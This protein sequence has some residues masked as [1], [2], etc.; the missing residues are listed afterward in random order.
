MSTI[1]DFMVPYHD[2]TEEEVKHNMKK[3]VLRYMLNKSKNSRKSKQVL[4]FD[5]ERPP[6]YKTNFLAELLWGDNYARVFIQHKICMGTAT[7]RADLQKL[8]ANRE[9]LLA[10]LSNPVPARCIAETWKGLKRFVNHTDSDKSRLGF[11]TEPTRQFGGSFSLVKPDDGHD[12]AAAHL[13]NSRYSMQLKLNA[14]KKKKKVIIPF[15]GITEG[16]PRHD[17]WDGIV[18]LR[19]ICMAPYSR[20]KLC[21][22]TSLKAG[23]STD[24]EEEQ[25]PTAAALQRQCDIYHAATK[26]FTDEVHRAFELQ[27]DANWSYTRACEQKLRRR[28]GEAEDF[29]KVAFKAAMTESPAIAAAA[30]VDPQNTSTQTQISSTRVTTAS[31]HAN[32]ASSMVAPVISRSRPVAPSQSPAGPA[33]HD[34]PVTRGRQPKRQRDRTSPPRN[35]NPLGGFKGEAAAAAQADYRRKKNVKFGNA[36]PP[37]YKIWEEESMKCVRREISP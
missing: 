32:G 30:K 6:L 11:G 4:D 12:D 33:S 34:E 31:N 26:G 20:S 8:E 17:W 13:A 29:L 9:A 5:K 36:P 27:Y 21:H 19:G 35:Q 22:V 3:V 23:A 10:D 7:F 24:V 1:S 14:M 18:D 16:L 2:A 15:P 37:K 28:K 25:Q